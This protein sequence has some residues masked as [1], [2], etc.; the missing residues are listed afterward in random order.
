MGGSAWTAPM[1]ALFDPLTIGNVEFA[2]RIW[3][4]P[5]WQ[6]MAEDG[7][8]GQWHD[9]RLD[10]RLGICGISLSHGK[11]AEFPAATHIN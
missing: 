8:V 2:N 7:F 5:M 1:S 11:N 9:V 4:S 6:Y 10:S 3:V